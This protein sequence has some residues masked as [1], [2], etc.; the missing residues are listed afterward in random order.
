MSSV[1]VPGRANLIGEHTDYNDGLALPFAIEAT[2]EV[3]RRDDPTGR[4]VVDADRFGRYVVGDEPMSEWERQVAAVFSLV[5]AT[6]ATFSVT[7]SVPVGAGLSS[8]AAFV[9]AL[10]LAAGATGTL[11]ELAELVR[12][13]EARA[14]NAVGLLDQFATLGARRDQ[15]MLIDFSTDTYEDVAWPPDLACTAVHTGV[16]RSL[17]TTSYQQRRAECETARNLLGGWSNATIE[18]VDQLSDPALRRRARHVVTERDRVLECVTALRRGDVA[19]VGR[20]V[21][22]SHRSLSEDFE[23]STPAIDELVASICADPAVYGARLMGGGF[24][25]C[26]IVVHHATWT[27]PREHDSW[28]LR[29]SD[30]ALSRLGRPR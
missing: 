19:E 29:A 7:S 23:V 21:T 8:S 27:P 10:A 30:G 22:A 16:T 24:G 14:G 9:G 26:V 1:A 25:G 20:L 11:L 15:L 4:C 13:A 18:A 17:A 28:S 12:E 5:S 2:V 3:T 6:S